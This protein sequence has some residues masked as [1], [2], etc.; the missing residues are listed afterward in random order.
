MQE[1]A[2][3]TQYAW[4]TEPEIDIERQKILMQRLG[5]Q[6]DIQQSIYPFKDIKLSRADIE[7]LLITHANGHGPVDWNDRKQRGLW[8]LD[9]RGA[10]LRQVDLRNLPLV[11]LR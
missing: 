4:R 9:L 8:G 2:N 10:D 3:K 6:P 5:V 7:W 11:R 1:Q